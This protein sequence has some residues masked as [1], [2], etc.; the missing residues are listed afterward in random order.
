VKAVRV[1]RN[2]D[3]APEA[4]LWRPWDEVEVSDSVIRLV[5][6]TGPGQAVA[7]VYREA[8][9][10]TLPDHDVTSPAEAAGLVQAAAQVLRFTSDGRAAASRRL[11]VETFDR[12]VAP[13]GLFR[14]QGLW[15]WAVDPT[16]WAPVFRAHFDAGF[17][18]NPD[19][20]GAGLIPMGL[21]EGEWKAWAM[22]ATGGRG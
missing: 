18:L 20:L 22:A 6:P 5:L 1:F 8:W 2:V 16:S 9:T 21:S 7:V 3:R 14:R 15:F 12:L 13:S 4:G 11:A 19:A 17:L 10:G